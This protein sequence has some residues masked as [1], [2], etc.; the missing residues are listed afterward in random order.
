MK[1]AQKIEP[2]KEEFVSDMEQR[3][4]YAAV[5]DAQMRLS[6]EEFV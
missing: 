5:K 1:G 4:N 6:K 3:S 2:L